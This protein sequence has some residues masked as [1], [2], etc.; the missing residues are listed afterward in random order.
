[1]DERIDIALSQ[2]CLEAARSL[3]AD[4]L[5]LSCFVSQWETGSFPA[6]REEEDLLAAA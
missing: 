2:A 5:K 6:E 4:I 3:G 1:M